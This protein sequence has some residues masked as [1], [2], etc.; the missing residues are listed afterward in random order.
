MKSVIFLITLSL[1][2]GR[3]QAEANGATQC[4]NTQATN[5]NQITVPPS[6]AGA[7]LQP[8]VSNSPIWGSSSTGPVS[9]PNNQAVP[10]AVTNAKNA[11]SA[12]PSN[13]SSPVNTSTTPDPTNA[14]GN[15]TNLTPQAAGGTVTPSCQ[16][17]NSESYFMSQNIE[18][19]DS[20]FDI[21]DSNGTISYIITNQIEGLNLT[22]NEAV[23]QNA[24]T[25]EKKVRIDVSV[26]SCGFDQKYEADDG[27]IFN[28]KTRF[29][30]PDRWRI[31][32][33]SVK[34][35]YKRAAMSLDGDI[36]ESKTGRVVASVST[37]VAS[38]LVAGSSKQLRLT[39]DDTIPTWDLI[40]LLV[41]AKTRVR[42]CGY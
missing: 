26:H 16:T 6:P 41:A 40:A 4:I 36:V 28:L 20:K 5:P 14:F 1:H 42:R 25:G 23:V 18:W 2:L 8:Q 11:S 39:S 22:K 31:Y 7:S 10:T 38:S 15:A 21:S 32:R 13:S 3:S 29:F 17:N 12:S 24:T 37:R 30:L 33:N 19:R 9:E 35:T 27:A 34:Y